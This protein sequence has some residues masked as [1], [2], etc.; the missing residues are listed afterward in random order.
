VEKEDNKSKQVSW[1]IPDSLRHR[2]TSHAEYLAAEKETSTESMVSVWLEE[3]LQLEER[4]RALR[5]LALEEK[6]LLKDR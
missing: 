4:K 2:L 6:D 3:R 1:R 5:T